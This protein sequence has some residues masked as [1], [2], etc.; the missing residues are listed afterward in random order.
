MDKDFDTWNTQKK[1]IDSELIS[2]PYQE[3][4]IWWC[5]VG[6][7]IGYEEDGHG[8]RAERPVLIVRGFSR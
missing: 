8:K 6:V 3:R 5:S 1:S 2:L 4:D 7:N